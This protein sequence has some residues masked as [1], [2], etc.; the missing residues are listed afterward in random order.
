MCYYAAGD[1]IAQQNKFFPF[2]FRTVSGTLRYERITESGTVVLARFSNPKTIIGFETIF[3]C[4]L[5]SPVRIVAETKVIA[6]QLNGSFIL[7]YLQTNT[8]LAYRFFTEIGSLGCKLPIDPET[9]INNTPIN[10]PTSPPS[11]LPRTRDRSTTLL[12]PDL[13]SSKLIL[14][15]EAT[16]KSGKSVALYNIALSQTALFF[17]ITENSKTLMVC[18]I[19]IIKKGFYIYFIFIASNSIY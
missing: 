12:I 5:R 18:I 4:N 16:V 10:G 6:K 8:T 17:Y 3:R 7:R 13:I 9:E 15:C 19:C 11:P 2:L 1:I 14:E